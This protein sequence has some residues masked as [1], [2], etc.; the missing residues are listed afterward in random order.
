MRSIK[1]AK[2]RRHEMRPSNIFLIIVAVSL[3]S[4]SPT[5]AT[6]GLKP[7]Y[8]ENKVHASVDSLQ[9][10]LRWEPFPSEGMRATA[11]Q[12]SKIRDITYD[13]NIWLSENDY[14]FSLIYTRRGLPEP[15]HKVEESLLPCAKYFWT[16]RARFL[17]DGKER[18]SEWGISATLL[19]WQDPSKS[20]GITVV[21]DEFLRRFPVVPHPNLY[22]FET[23]FCPEETLGFPQ[24]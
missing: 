8:P 13:L 9:P 20:D 12:I 16:V 22:R 5:F 3:A 23:P 4:C 7:L 2:C 11:E 6:F 10:V 19:F 18:V 21:S 15:R 1:S 24:K 14:P 17:I